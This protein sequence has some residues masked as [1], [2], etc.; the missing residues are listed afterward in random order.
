MFDLRYLE[1][2]RPG[3]L[4]YEKPS[5]DTTDGDF[6]A[7]RRAVP[8]GWTRDLN[9]EWATFAPDG[10]NLPRQ[11]WKI[12]VSATLGNAESVLATVWDHCVRHRVMFKFLRGPDVLRQRN[13]K[14]ADRGSSGKF[15]T[16]YPRDDAELGRM[17]H[18]LDELLGGAEGPYI[19]SDL[20]WRSGPLYVRYG[21][22][23]A[24][25]GRDEAGEL[26]H[27][28]EDPEGRLVPDVRGPAFR[29][30]PWVEL[31]EI[32]GEALAARDSGILQD[33]PFR[34][35][36]ALHFSNG[37]GVYRATDTRTGDEVLLKEARPLAGLD[38]HGR[39]AVER[40]RR[41]HWAL[42]RL[43]G[44]TCVPQMID[45]R[46]GHEHYYLARAF[47][48]GTR[49]DQ[50]VAERNPLLRGDAPDSAFAA[51]TEWA[52]KILDAVE[53]G[54]RRMHEQG[55][56]FGDLHPG[57]ILIGPDDGVFFVDF[58]SA[59]PL[60]SAVEQA[61]GAPGYSAPLGYAGADV[62]RYAFG[63]LCLGVFAPLTVLMA[64]DLRKIEQLVDEV[65]AAFPLPAGFADR[66][67]RALG[68]A[69]IPEG[70]GSGAHWPEILWPDP[71][72]ASWPQSR[73]RIAGG[74][75]DAAE[76]GR[77]D[78]LY[79][80]DIQQFLTPGGGLS[81]ANGAAGVIWALDQ[82]GVAVP[83]E[84]VDW[85][86][87]GIERTGRIGPGFYTGLAGIAY[88][89]ERLGHADRAGE[90][91]RRAAALPRDD[92]NGSLLD[93][94][95]GLGLTL[96]HFAR[97][98]GDHG[99]ADEA[100]KIADML[101][102]GSGG[103]PTRPGLLHGGAGQALL[104]LRLHEHAGDDGLLDLAER[105]L[106]RDMDILGWTAD[107]EIDGH[108]WLRVV[109]GLSGGPGLGMVVHDLLRHRDDPGLR[110]VLDA[111]R[112]A[113]RSRLILGAGLFGGRAGTVLGLRHMSGDGSALHRHLTGFGLHALPH[114]EGRLAFFGELGL[115]L[116]ADLATG[117]AGV[118]L[119][120][121]TVLN[122]RPTPLPFF[123]GGGDR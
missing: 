101:A 81:L 36:Q 89:L 62:D 104:F 85:L 119:A 34:V 18:E 27:C 4:F 97:R 39:D 58:E 107:Q 122:D 120:V 6:P 103:A 54:V 99:H 21:G 94:L 106:R 48:E 112:R 23:V 26:V 65:T 72:R 114:P 93:G 95:A 31:P 69:P 51:Y 102:A 100:C 9:S 50:V 12:H 14:Y 87:S 13:G 98:T 53:Q 92:L 57:N 1:F 11:G 60:E 40:L 83:G 46:R 17:L 117:A 64:W 33:F 25:M 49:L 121:D 30:P 3:L 7:A 108:E 105:A 19:L 109:H 79:P 22:F 15:V 76:P 66:V 86:L 47:V 55:V 80:G 78:R 35:Y 41:E 61:M 84:H 52:L 75:L 8:P 63:C 90:V 115:R 28:V 59:S 24:R 16:I 113:C 68:P 37:G 118:L 43:S 123:D 45:F 10:E 2:C 111:C 70:G 77:D 116:S 20:R 56:V 29:P 71:D 32:L 38:N 110:R 5:N 73:A 67:W 44:L 91:L 96:L 82:A 74:I 88:A 42:E